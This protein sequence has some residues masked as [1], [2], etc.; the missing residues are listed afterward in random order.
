MQHTFNTLAERISTDTGSY[1][2]DGLDSWG[3]L[4]GELLDS[5]CRSRNDYRACESILMRGAHDILHDLNQRA[6]FHRTLN[7]AAI[8]QPQK[9]K[10]WHWCVLSNTQLMRIGLVTVFRG[11]PIPAHDHPSSFGVQQ[12]LTGN[13][14]IRQYQ[15][16]V[17]FDQKHHL[18]SLQKISD[19]ELGKDRNSMFTPDHCNIHEIESLTPRAVLLSILVHPFDPQNRSWFFPASLSESSN[20]KLYSRIRKRSAFGQTKDH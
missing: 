1:V 17:P 19:C 18:V 4:I 6:E 8:C 9:D 7:Q 15:P 2:I 13:V 16:L 12:V 20:D 10:S 3:N 5:N 11:S 14:H